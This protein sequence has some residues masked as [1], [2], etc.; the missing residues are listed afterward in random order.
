MSASK[1]L[2]SPQNAASNVEMNRAEFEA[3]FRQLASSM[4]ARTENISCIASSDC[5][6]CTDC[7]FCERCVGANRCHYCIECT[8]CSDCSHCTRCTGC[9]GC[10]HC[11]ESERCN[12]SAYLVRSVGCVSCNYCFGC[13][14]LKGRDFHILNQPY[15]RKSY[16]EITERL[17]K[18]LRIA[19]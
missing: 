15:D 5:Q 4:A 8:E 2:T 13:V 6:R 1:Q 17:M 16:F 3:A 19:A 10:T 7:T 14:G 12:S 11:V 9:L 18:E